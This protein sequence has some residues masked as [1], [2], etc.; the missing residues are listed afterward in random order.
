MSDS[1]D[2]I[3]EA[4]RQIAA[5]PLFDLIISNMRCIR[6]IVRKKVVLYTTSELDITNCWREESNPKGKMQ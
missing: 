6:L 2:Q 3:K 4:D 5:D 1:T